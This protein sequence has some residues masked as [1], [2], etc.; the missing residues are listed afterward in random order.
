[1][2]PNLPPRV[3]LPKREH[4]VIPKR[5]HEVIPKR[6]HEVI[7]K[8]EHRSLP[9]LQSLLTKGEYGLPDLP[10]LPKPEHHA[11]PWRLVSKPKSKWPIPRTTLVIRIGHRRT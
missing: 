1:M 10:D 8:G 4:G 2:T 6:E 9:P 7:P 3:P 11:P 5:E